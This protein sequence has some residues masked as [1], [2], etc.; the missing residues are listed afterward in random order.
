MPTLRYSTPDAW[1]QRVLDDFDAF[2]NDH[3]AAE[4]KASGMALSMALHYHDRPDIVATMADLAVEELDHFRSVVRLLHDRGLN[5]SRD[6]KDIYIN[7]LRD[8]IRTGREHYLLDRLLLGAVVE[9][10]GAERFGLIATALPDGELKAFYQA[11]TASEMRHE[12]L[13]ER[14]ARAHFPATEVDLRLGQWLAMEARIIAAQPLRP[15][16]H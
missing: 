5:L 4:K 14:L 16:L 9:A 7:S 8:E 1:T 15:A 3:A 13:F 2:L 12:N 10:R 6:K 11:I